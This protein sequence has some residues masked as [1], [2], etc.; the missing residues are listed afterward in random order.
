MF[1]DL[2]SIRGSTSFTNG[3]GGFPLNMH[4]VES[5]LGPQPAIFDLEQPEPD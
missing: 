2:K 4:V 3:D 1:G 5:W